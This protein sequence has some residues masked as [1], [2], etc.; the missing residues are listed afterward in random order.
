MSHVTHRYI[1]LFALAYITTSAGAEL[2]IHELKPLIRCVCSE[3]CAFQKIV[4][5]LLLPSTPNPMFAVNLTFSEE[6]VTG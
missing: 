2:I 4:E 3:Y 1:N 5:A 6:C